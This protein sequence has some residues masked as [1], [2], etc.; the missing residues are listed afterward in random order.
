MPDKEQG[1]PDTRAGSR[2][3]LMTEQRTGLLGPLRQP[4]PVGRSRAAAPARP[5]RLG[6]PLRIVRRRRERDAAARAENLSASAIEDQLTADLLIRDIT[7]S[8]HRDLTVRIQAGIHS[9]DRFTVVE[10]LS[11]RERLARAAA[12]RRRLS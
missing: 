8:A 1:L 11:L 2:R 3:T 6:L 12:A 4:R 10:G 5:G 7:G 9:D